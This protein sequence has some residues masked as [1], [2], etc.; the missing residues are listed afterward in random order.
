MFDSQSA[1]ADGLRR[2]VKK[3]DSRLTVSYFTAE[4]LLRIDLGEETIAHV[5]LEFDTDFDEL[6][7]SESWSFDQTDGQIRENVRKVLKAREDKPQ[8]RMSDVA[9]ANEKIVDAI[10]D[11]PAPFILSPDQEIAI[12]N[13]LS[14]LMSDSDCREA[15][16]AG[17]AG[18]GKSTVAKEIEKRWGVGKVIYMTPTGKAAVRI[19][20]T[21]GKPAKTIHSSIYRMVEEVTKNG[22]KVP[23][24][25]APMP[26]EG[27]DASTLI[28]VDEAFMVGVQLAND[29]RLTI[30][31]TG[32][33]ILFMGDREQLPPVDSKWGVDPKNPT[34]LLTQVHRQAEGSPILDLATRIRT[35]GIDALMTFDRWDESCNYFHVPDVESAAQFACLPGDR[36]VL[37]FTHKI[38]QLI[39]SRI[40]QIQGRKEELEVGERLMITFN[41]HAL[42]VMNGEIGTVVKCSKQAAFSLIMNASIYWV[43]LLVD[44]R[45]EPIKILV[46]PS[47]LGI[48]DGKKERSIYYEFWQRMWPRKNMPKGEVDKWEE[49]RQS[50]VKSKRVSWRDVSELRDFNKLAAQVTWGSCTTVH[51][52]QGSQY[53]HVCFVA[54]GVLRSMAE[55][56]PETVRRLIYTAVTRASKTLEF[57]DV[58]PGSGSTPAVEAASMPDDFDA[59][60]DF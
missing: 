34:G 8:T 38:R 50:L 24:F 44:G 41:L 7:E 30:G 49:H 48:T 56:D 25:S 47:L 4:R 1:A 60:P 11:A 9:K 27:C 21:S 31:P 2:I 42:G 37:T 35:N 55:R 33:A 17:A 10:G 14:L 3:I 20:Q 23:K 36:I 6:D 59:V 39:A 46:A 57:H 28:V 19:R 40:R 16:L 51:K 5:Y 43:E 45:E 52:S 58:V 13:C 54:C 53:E 29:L 32:A 12:T 26:P 15:V 22:N 18:T